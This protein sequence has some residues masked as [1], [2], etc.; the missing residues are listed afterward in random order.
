VDT[1]GRRGAA[2]VLIGLTIQAATT[3]LVIVV[4]GNVLGAARFSGVSLLYVLIASVTTGLFLP[5]EQE[6]ARRRGDGRGRGTWDDTLLRR[7]ITLALI[8][9]VLAIVVAVA[10]ET[11]MLRL[12]GHNA[13]LLAALCVAI[14]GYA[15]CFISRGEFA[16]R[17]QLMRYGVAL[18][19][20]GG[21]RFVGALALVVVGS[22]SPA[23]YGW[24]FAIAPWC[25][26]AASLPGWRATGDSP[27]VR[28]TTPLARAIGLLA[29]SSFASQLLINAGPLIVALLASPTQHAEAGVFLAA[30]VMVRV[31][32]FLFSAVQPSFLPGM[33]EHAA[34]DRR[35]EFLTLVAKVL[36]MVGALIALSCVAV[37]AIGS[38][39]LHIVY[40]HFSRLSRVTLLEMSLSVGFFLLAAILAQALLGRN[41]HIAVTAGWLVGVVALVVGTSLG[42]G[43]TGR[44]SL[45]FLFGS[46]GCT[47]AFLALIAQDLRRWT[48]PAYSSV[49]RS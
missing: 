16:G 1:G 26:L 35:A 15:C 36:A 10:A 6:I 19:V 5:L 43:P 22:H 18:G 44:A 23:A 34:A 49:H 31:P 38:Q 12:L 30:M 25:S 21:V 40:P 4:I 8:V 13:G 20:E 46:I 24:L 7:S 48:V 47:V 42:H 2:A 28:D 3:L 29:V 14:P 9:S 17:G 45:G 11:I 33:A 37:V 39:L 41:Q 32:V 27:V